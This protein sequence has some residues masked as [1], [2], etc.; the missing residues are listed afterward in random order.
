VEKKDD[1]IIQK[2]DELKAAY[3][4]NKDVYIDGAK[5]TSAVGKGASKNPISS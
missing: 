2:L 4:S 5:V 1:L 3:M